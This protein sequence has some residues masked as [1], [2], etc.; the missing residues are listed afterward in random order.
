MNLLQS[1]LYL[2][3]VHVR[4]DVDHPDLEERGESADPANLDGDEPAP[5]EGI[6]G[7][8]ELQIIVPPGTGTPMAAL[9]AGSVDTPEIA[10]YLAEL[11]EFIAE[12]GVSP[13][14]WSVREITTMPKAPGRPVAIPPRELWPNIVGTLELYTTLR[15]RM[16]VPLSLRGYR[17][18]S[19]NA[20]V[21]GAK[22]SQHLWFGA[23]D[24]YAPKGHKQRLAREAARLYLELEDES[25]GFGAY[26]YPHPSNIHL[27]TGYRRR[28]WREAGKWIKAVQ[29]EDA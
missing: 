17:D 20:A 29:R 2:L 23:L 4:P 25:I 7:P 13:E 14:G 10:S 22:R 21:D 3:R 28:I 1:L 15:R 19:Y 16:D 6:S 24:L 9:V 12:Y 5:R 26:G 27:D 18:R 11:R 8:P